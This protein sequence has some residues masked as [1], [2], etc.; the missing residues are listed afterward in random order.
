[1][2]LEPLQDYLL[3]KIQLE[4]PRAS[5]I[6]HESSPRAGQRA[7]VVRCGPEVIDIA[8]R[9]IVLVNTDRGIQVGEEMLI[10]EA[11]ILAVLSS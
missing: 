2:S 9:D 8:P 3:V 7:I 5:P 4:A 6:I 11:G 10:P 1:M